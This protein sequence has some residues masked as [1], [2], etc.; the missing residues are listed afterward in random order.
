MFLYGINRHDGKIVHHKLIFANDVV[1]E[2]GN[3]VNNYAAPSP[4]LQCRCSTRLRPR[5][6]RV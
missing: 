2:L 1:E 4:V 3:P 5:S 6:P